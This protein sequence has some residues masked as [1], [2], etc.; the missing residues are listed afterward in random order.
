MIQ[1]AAYKE[2]KPMFGE[3]L[4]VLKDLKVY[5]VSVQLAVK[6]SQLS[7][8]IPE[9][10]KFGFFDHVS[11]VATSVSLNIAKGWWR[12]SNKDFT[13]FLV[14]AQDSWLQGVSAFNLTEDLQRVQ[15]SR[16]QAFLKNPHQLNVKLIALIQ[17][18][19]KEAFT[20]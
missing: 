6:M 15:H 14:Q 10:R 20:L 9:V 11:R 17:R 19:V 7:Q 5:C 2:P 4:F 1:S 3:A 16:T 12:S 13:H 18:L 8:V